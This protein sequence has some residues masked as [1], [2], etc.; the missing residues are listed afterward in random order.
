MAAGPSGRAEALAALKTLQMQHPVDVTGSQ[1]Y[2][3]S[4][5]V[6]KRRRQ[7]LGCCAPQRHGRRP[8][9][10]PAASSRKNNSVQLRVPMTVR[11]TSRHWRVQISHAPAGPATFQ[12]CAGLRIVDDAPI[13]WKPP[14]SGAAT[15]SPTGVMR[16]RSGMASKPPVAGATQGGRPVHSKLP[17]KLKSKRQGPVSSCLPSPAYGRRG[18][19]DDPGRPRRLHR[20]GSAGCAGHERRAS[21]RPTEDRRQSRRHRHD[22]LTE[23]VFVAVLVKR[24]TR[25]GA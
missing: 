8:A 4:E 3:P 17:P 12:Q 25:A 19:S 11:R 7:R 9:A 6:G 21:R 13:S 22:R 24:K 5:F 15:R 1:C 14:R 20:R 23:V 2:G 18:T 16:F 10:R